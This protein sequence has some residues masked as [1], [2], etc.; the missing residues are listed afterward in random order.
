MEQRLSWRV[1][2]AQEM[3][4]IPEPVPGTSST[5]R[6]KGGVPMLGWDGVGLEQQDE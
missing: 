5:G 1:A 4:A 6:L 3:S 2:G